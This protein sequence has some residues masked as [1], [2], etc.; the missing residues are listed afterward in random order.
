MPKVREIKG[1]SRKS[2]ALRG[3]IKYIMA[4][5]GTPVSEKVFL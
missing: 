3:V 2:R 5:I 4:V 1:L